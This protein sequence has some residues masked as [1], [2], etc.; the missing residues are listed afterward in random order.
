V[1]FRLAIRRAISV[2][3]L[4]TILNI[5]SV[6]ATTISQ[7]AGAGIVSLCSMLTTQ[8]ELK[9]HFRTHFEAFELNPG[10]I[11]ELN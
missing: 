2:Y 5:T 11:C 9:R 4:R 3:A 8:R 6:A 1:T 7:M 10:V